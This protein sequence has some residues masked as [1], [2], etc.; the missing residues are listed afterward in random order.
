MKEGRND[1]SLD[2]WIIILNNQR[3]SPKSFISDLYLDARLQFEVKRLSKTSKIIDFSA[4]IFVFFL[5]LLLNLIHKK[6]KKE[7]IIYEKVKDQLNITN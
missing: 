4:I 3:I 5:W 6:L 1:N 2:T 7:V